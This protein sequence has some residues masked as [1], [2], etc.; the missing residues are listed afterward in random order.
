MAEKLTPQQF[1]AV[2]NRGGKLL[3]S[4]AA[5][6]GKTKVLVDRLLSYMKDPADPA[7]IDEFLIITYTKAAAAELRGK[8]A[9]KLS[10][11]IADNPESKHLQRQTQKLYLTKI[12]TVHAFCTDL[13]RE[14][15]YALDVPSDF[16]VADERE[17]LELK[18]KAMDFVLENAY[19]SLLADSDFVTFIDTQGIGRDDRQVPQILL[20]VY[21]RAKCHLDPDAWL[22]WCV[23]NCEL[24]DLSDAG[25]TVWGQYLMERLFDYTQYHINALKNCIQ[26]CQCADGFEKPAQLLTDTVFQLERLLSS[27]TWDDVVKN[28]TIDYGRLTFPKSCTD[29]QLIDKVKAV[30]SACKTGLENKLRSFTDDSNQI[31]ADMQVTASATRGLVRLVHEF[32]AAYERLKKSRRVLDFSDLEHKTLDLLTGKRRGEPTSLALEIGR[33]FRE[34]MV[35]EYQDSNAVQDKIFSALTS[36]RQNCF[37]VGDVKQS[38]YEFRLADPTIFLSKYNDYNL[39]ENAQD[40]SGRKVMLSSNFRSASAV[41]GAVNDVFRTCMSEQTGGLDYGDAEAL[42]EGIEHIA[43]DEPEIEFHGI[44]VQEDTYA[45]EAA[46]TAQRISELLNGNHFVRGEGAALR[47][48]V[49]DDIVILLRSPGSV[50]AEFVYALQKRGISCA[51]DATLDLLQTEEISVLRSLLQVISNPLQDIPLLAALSS[52]VFSFTADDLVHVRCTDRYASIYE[53]LCDCNIDK[54]GS[55]VSIIKQIRAEARLISLSHL[56]ELVLAKT[57]LDSIFAAMP[58]G[59]QRVENLQSFCQIAAQCESSYGCDLTRFL[60]YLDTMDESGIAP[61]TD[62]VTTGSV[63]IMSIHKS[64][65]LEFPVVFLC[66]LSRSFNKRSATE[67]VLCDKTLGLGLSCVDTQNRVRYPSVAKRAIATKILSDGL[68]EEMR[69]L[70]VAMTRAKDRLVMTYASQ[71][72]EKDILTMS[73]RLDMS[74]MKLMAMEADCPGDWVLMAALQR[75]EAGALFTIGGRPERTVVHDLPWLISVHSQTVLE[76]SAE[77]DD[78]PESA[79]DDRIQKI[80]SH[81][82]SF[83]YP[84]ML[85]TKTPSKQTATQLKGRNKD[86]EILENSVHRIHPQNRWRDPSFVC[87]RISEKSYGTAIHAVMQ[88]VDYNKC[89]DKEGV[90]NEIARLKQARYISEEQEKV[91]DVDAITNFFLT[92]IG[93]KLRAAKDVLREFKFTILED[94]EIIDP[95]L[96]NEQILLQGV[97]DCAIIDDDGITVIDFKTDKVTDETVT[98]V[99]EKYRPQVEA[100]G[101]A[102]SRIYELPVKNKFL[103]FFSLGRT[104]SL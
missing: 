95:S 79:L 26:C 58:D 17:A 87:D 74:G 56:I 29:T 25:Q 67:S 30:R 64:K 72:L 12:S 63:R 75:T 18:L 5:G 90:V 19:D 85:A 23:L 32:S 59:Q 77:R 27:E 52:R 81:A 104:I 48:I 51:A 53:A 45:E 35:D 4:A 57:R 42:N 100:Y 89:A 10:Q 86:Q 60:E 80:L 41:I 71:S 50:G 21:D 98:L 7:N 88:F 84:H 16:R 2:H 54:A 83:R 28:S 91:A 24:D 6:S 11:E 40:G 8:I 14:F 97:V 46:F 39:A 3:V 9:A 103:Y 69:V 62:C 82:L 36:L 68:S 96:S 31:L 65:G 66:G 1:E 61:A 20:R 22:H 73:A 93:C 102:I 78:E 55:F 13:I 43:I 99:S 76:G 70:Y 94:A 34:V 44:D 49:P 47:P 33:R 92:D 15:S 101:I 38:I 37:M